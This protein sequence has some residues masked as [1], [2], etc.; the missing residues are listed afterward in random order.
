MLQEEIN[1][2][3]VGFERDLFEFVVFIQDLEDGHHKLSSGAQ[4][5]QDSYHPNRQ[6]Q[7]TPVENNKF[8]D[9]SAMVDAFNIVECVLLGLANLIDQVGS[10]PTENE[11]IENSNDEFILKCYTEYVYQI[12]S[13]LVKT[14]EDH[15]SKFSA[16]LDELA[17]PSSSGGGKYESS[18]LRH[19]Q[20]DN[21][22]EKAKEPKRE[23]KVKT[24]KPAALLT[25]DD[26]KYHGPHVRQHDFEYVHPSKSSS[27]EES[28]SDVDDEYYRHSK[29]RHNKGH[30]W[31]RKEHE[32]IEAITNFTDILCYTAT[33]F[34]D[35]FVQL[36]NC[37]ISKY[38]QAPVPPTGTLY[39]YHQ[40]RGGGIKPEE[41]CCPEKCNKWL[42]PCVQEQ[43][44]RKVIFFIYII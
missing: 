14:V 37:P 18:R 13:Y 2:L 10:L 21:G 6:F 11:I 26:K 41:T 31:K 35:L 30:S 22:R 8:P 25:S 44:G 40:T 42:L 15:L 23:F 17:S 7:K 34:Q 1:Q 16:Q 19:T 27:S 3:L 33:I 38:I 36:K 9:S 39:E 20:L 29:I 24:G 43:Q 28:E 5:G 32:L 12:V 4:K